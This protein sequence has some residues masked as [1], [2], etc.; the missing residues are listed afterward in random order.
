MKAELLMSQIR[1]L[2]A[3]HED[4]MNAYV[5]Y[6]NSL[7][8]QDPFFSGALVSKVTTEWLF[9]NEETIDEDLSKVYQNGISIYFETKALA[10]QNDFNDD[11]YRVLRVSFI[12]IRRITKLKNL[13]KDLYKNNKGE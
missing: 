9:F 12:L 5:N 7:E 11:C 13:Y 4:C 3:I 2:D 6:F 1:R 8:L 10:A